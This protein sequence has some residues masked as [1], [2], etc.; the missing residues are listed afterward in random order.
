[1]QRSHK[2][3]S[4]VDIRLGRTVFIRVCLLIEVTL[5]GA[6]SRYNT[7]IEEILFRGVCKIAKSDY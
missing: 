2:V 7:V 1:L 6:T 5:N 4:V 3:I